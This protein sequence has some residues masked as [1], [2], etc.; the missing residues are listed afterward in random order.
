MVATTTPSIN[1]VLPRLIAHFPDLT[2]TPSDYFSW[3]PT[4]HTVLFAASGT[5]TELL[6]EIGHAQA[7]HTGYARDIELLRYEREAWDQAEQIATLL[8]TP[9]D[10]TLVEDHLDSYRDWMH[11]RSQCVAC[12]ETGI[13]TARHR[14]QCVTCGTTWRVNDAR[15]CQLRRYAV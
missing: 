2:F 7:H 8:D 5:L 14:Y 9:L 4:T 6:H 10:Q 13:E 11:Q 1:S 3:Q 15:R 12:G